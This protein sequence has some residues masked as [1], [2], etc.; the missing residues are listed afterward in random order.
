LEIGTDTDADA[1]EDPSPAARAE[2][3]RLIAAELPSDYQTTLHPA[4]PE[5]PESRF[6]SLIQQELERKELGD[7]IV[8]GI[9]LSRYEAPEA[10]T[11][12]PNQNPSDI[13]DNWKQTLRRAYTA[14]SHLSGRL[15][16]LSLLEEYG[17]NA[18][19]IGN[20][21][22]EEMLRQVEKELEETK[23]ATEAVNKERK[24]R[25]ETAKAELAGLE[26]AWRRAVSGTI[27]VEIAA[28]SLRMET[29]EKRRQQARG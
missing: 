2:I 29:L 12:D 26:D 3:A 11:A 18:W 13:L 4:I 20:A 1:D 9:D 21:Q 15:E 17:K 5:L 19:L 7:P 22:L 16:N 28:E 6:S 8:G 23:Q 14:S 24:L 25:Q 10:P 27:E